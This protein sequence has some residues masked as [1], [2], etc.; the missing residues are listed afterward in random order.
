VP[1]I[2]VPTS[3]IEGDALRYTVELQNP[4]A[5]PVRLVNC[6]DVVQSLGNPPKF[7]EGSAIETPLNCAAAPPAIRPHSSVTFAFEIDTSE[8]VIPSTYTAH[9]NVLLRWELV[10]GSQT[11]LYEQTTATVTP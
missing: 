9:P 11:L 8:V 10:D 7:Y 5:T 6:P 3:V 2:H 4:T 1:I